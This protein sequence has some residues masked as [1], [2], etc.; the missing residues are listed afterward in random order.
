MVGGVFC[1]FRVK[2]GEE[3]LCEVELAHVGGFQLVAQTVGESANACEIVSSTLV[4]SCI[5][6]N[7]RDR[8]DG[9]HEFLVQTRGIHALN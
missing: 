2:R 4:G 5:S 1:R 3:R 8:R 7:R 6:V 9:L